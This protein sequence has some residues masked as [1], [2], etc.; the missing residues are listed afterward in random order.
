MKKDQTPEEI[1]R[2]LTR[3]KK[4]QTP[5]E[6]E[7]QQSRFEA[8]QK[9]NPT[10]TFKDFFAEGA[11]DKLTRGRPHMTLG[12]SLHTGDYETAGVGLFKRLQEE[13]LTPDDVCVD[14]GCGTLRVGQH[15][16][17]FLKPGAYWGLDIDSFLLDEGRKLI[18]EKLLAEKRPNL[19]VISPS[20]VA[21]AA[22]AEPAML[23]SFAVLIHVHPL[24]LPEYLRNLT[25]I[26]GTKGKAI[27]TGRWSLDDSIQYSGQSWAHALATL[28]QMLDERGATLTIVREEDV[29]LEA[30]GQSVKQGVLRISAAR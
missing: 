3:L 8:W 29:E 11:R 28:K 20:S 30:F 9:R 4:H 25:T 6:V 15:V 21:E 1:Q 12:K 19:R 17:N 13:G 26:I 24:E 2:H 16:M 5:E 27:L 23:G 18:G 10:K 14:Y 7:R 22:A